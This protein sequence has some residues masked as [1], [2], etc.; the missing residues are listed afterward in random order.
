MGTGFFI[1]FLL[2]P[3]IALSAK[4]LLGWNRSIWLIFFV[5]IPLGWML[6]ILAIWSAEQHMDDLL[7][8][9]PDPSKELLDAWQ[10]DGAANVFALYLGWAIA[11]VYFLLCL[12]VINI[13]RDIKAA[14]NKRS[15]S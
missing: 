7:R 6:W 12:I 5:W 13:I 9:N 15:R 2:V 14:L 11:A 1:A 10:N 3:L 8:S 4:K